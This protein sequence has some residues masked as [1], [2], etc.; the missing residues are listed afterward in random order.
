MKW[1]Y[2]KSAYYLEFTIDE[3]ERMK[4]GITHAVKTKNNELIIIRRVG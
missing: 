4:R 1:K 2:Q 3:L